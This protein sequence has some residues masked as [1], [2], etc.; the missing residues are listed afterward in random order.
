[1]ELKL[2][3]AKEVVPLPGHVRVVIKDFDSQLQQV[4]LWQGVA[5]AKVPGGIHLILPHGALCPEPLPKTARRLSYLTIKDEVSTE[6][7]I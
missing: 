4:C 7:D 5:A 2:C 3:L 1:M 6:L